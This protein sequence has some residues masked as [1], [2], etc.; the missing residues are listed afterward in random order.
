MRGVPQARC[1]SVGMMRA[2]Q[3]AGHL[4]GPATGRVGKIRTFR[5]VDARARRLPEHFA[6]L[7]MLHST[8]IEVRMSAM[9]VVLGVC[10]CIVDCGVE[11]RVVSRSDAD[12]GV[13][14]ECDE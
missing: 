10:L 4:D 5:G 9:E 6:F 7:S 12:H 8:R 1:S 11:T 3:R 13:S 14:R 2:N